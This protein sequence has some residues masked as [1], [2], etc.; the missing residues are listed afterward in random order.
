MVSRG[1]KVTAHVTGIAKMRGNIFWNTRAAGEDPYTY[2]A[3]VG[4]VLKGWDEGCLGMKVGEVRELII[5]GS[6]GFGGK[7]FK[8]WNI[9]PNETL[10]MTIEV[11]KIEQS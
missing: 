3:G 11:L 7:G 5:P 8:Q 9:F 6:E 1:S 10:F 4:R 2:E